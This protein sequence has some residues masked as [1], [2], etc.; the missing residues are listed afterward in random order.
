MRHELMRQAAKRS[1]AQVTQTQRDLV[2]L[3]TQL[4]YGQPDFRL[5]TDSLT[6]AS[7]AIGSAFKEMNKAAAA[8]QTLIEDWA[9]NGPPP[10]PSTRTL[11][12]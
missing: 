5:V 1:L 8:Y 11:I 2:T 4:E 6:T 3:V 9:K 10:D 12:A 7:E